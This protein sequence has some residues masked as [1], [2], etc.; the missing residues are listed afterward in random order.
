MTLFIKQAIKGGN[1]CDDAV[2]L[3]NNVL[4]LLSLYDVQSFWTSENEERKVWECDNLTL[5]A[6][7][8]DFNKYIA[9]NFECL[10]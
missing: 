10:P 9:K 2:I 8:I 6:S 5:I 7:I 3:L 4:S 1:Q